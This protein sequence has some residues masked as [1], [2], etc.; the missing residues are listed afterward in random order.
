MPNKSRLALSVVA[1]CFNEAAGLEEFHRRVREVCRS[2][3]GDRYEIVLVDDGSRDATWPIMCDIARSNHKVVAIRLSRNH[4]HQLALTA[5]LQHCKGE[6][7]L[8][9]DA[10]LQDP[11]ELLPAMMKIMDESDADVV[12]GQRRMRNGETRFKMLTAEM[13]YRLLQRL[14]DVPIPVDTGDFRLMSQRAVAVLNGMPEHYRFI[15]GMVSWIGMTQ[16]AFLYDRGARFAGQTKY[17]LSKMIR[18]AIDAITG[19]SIVPLRFASFMGVCVGL[20]SLVLLSYTLGSWAFGR[21]VEGWTSLSTIFL[22]VSSA[23]LL[24]LGCIGEY[25]GRL[26]MEAKNRP[27]FVIDKVIR[28]SPTPTKTKRRR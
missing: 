4:G 2:V 8:I 12:Y 9:I 18:F 7:V 6:R 13:F 10:D 26:Y 20:I 21:V 22:V 17:P 27:L 15:R 24:V 28:R 11:P 19:F 16:L 25:L 3:I 14:T 23:Q 5:G 1:P